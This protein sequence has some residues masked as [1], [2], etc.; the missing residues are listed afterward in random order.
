MVGH[1]KSTLSTMA[2]HQF[3]KE[4]MGKLFRKLSHS[5]RTRDELT[6]RS[7]W[8]S[9]QEVISL[10]FPNRSMTLAFS[11]ISKTKCTL[12]NRNWAVTNKRKNHRTLLATLTLS[13]TN[14]S[15]VAVFNTGPAE[16]PPAICQTTEKTC[17]WQRKRFGPSPTPTGIADFLC[18]VLWKT[19]NRVG[20]QALATTRQS[21]TAQ[22]WVSFSRICQEEA[23]WRL[24]LTCHKPQESL[25]W[26]STQATMQRSTE[27]DSCDLIP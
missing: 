16:V 20:C 4:S 24:R 2:T 7:R 1:I 21:T 15:L 25:L 26:P 6:G 22:W 11:M 3:S 14:P 17:L 8:V 18:G 5:T 13:M 27:M 10:R 23:Q 19:K 9:A 12:S